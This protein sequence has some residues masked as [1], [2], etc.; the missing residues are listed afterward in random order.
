M[1]LKYVG[2]SPS[3]AGVVPLPQGWPAHDHIEDD[4]DARAEKLAF[5]FEA[6]KLK[7]WGGKRAYEL[8]EEGE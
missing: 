3:E 2:P 5:K 8:V 1:E 7:G 4:D 6:R